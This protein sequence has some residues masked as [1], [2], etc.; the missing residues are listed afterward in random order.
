MKDAL[1]I[2]MVLLVLLLIISVFGG[3]VRPT[4]TIMGSKA[5]PVSSGMAQWSAVPQP[6]S[7]ETF[8]NAPPSM[9]AMP[10]SMP[11]MPEMPVSSMP[12]MPVTKMQTPATTEGFTSSVQPFSDDDKHATF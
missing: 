12:Q 7:G 3:S 8:A 11:E 5:A 2:F 9:P 1:V 4:H 10:T 6:W